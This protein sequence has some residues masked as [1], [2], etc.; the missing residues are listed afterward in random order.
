M[1]TQRCTHS[2]AKGCHPRNVH[3]AL[4]WSERPRSVLWVPKGVLLAGGVRA[5]LITVMLPLL[6]QCLVGRHSDCTREWLPVM[7]ER[8]MGGTE[9]MW[10]DTCKDQEM[11]WSPWMGGQLCVQTY[12]E[13]GK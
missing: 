9:H 4:L 13:L 10:R 8:G 1:Y 2:S 12:L 5:V 3:P 7:R 11:S 6:A